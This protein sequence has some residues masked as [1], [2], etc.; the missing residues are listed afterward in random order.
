M[1]RIIVFVV[2]LLAAVPETGKALERF[3]IVTTEE[4]Q[5]MLEQRKAKK[6]DFILVNTLDKMI[7]RHSHIPG[8]VNVPLG[9]IEQN[10]HKL[11]ADRTKLIVTYCMG[12]R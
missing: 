12:Y 10:V 3:D 4:M 2:L 9:Q 5:T 1:G 7:F 6:I 8:S 11:G